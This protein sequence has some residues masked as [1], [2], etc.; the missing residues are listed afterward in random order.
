MDVIYSF[1][2]VDTEKLSD[3]EL[4]TKAKHLKKKASNK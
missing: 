1:K 4:Q 3:L 2:C